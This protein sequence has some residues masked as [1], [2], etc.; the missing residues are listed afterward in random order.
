MRIT[1]KKWF[2]GLVMSLLT[3]ITVGSIT[4]FI[5]IAINEVSIESI[6]LIVG[7]FGSLITSIIVLPQIIAKHLFPENEDQQTND[8]I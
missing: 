4:T 6:A 8:L 2:F 3:V 7:A 1:L 5:L